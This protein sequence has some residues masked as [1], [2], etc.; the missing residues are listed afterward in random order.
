M[1]KALNGARNLITNGTSKSAISLPLLEK[2]CAALSQLSL[3]HYNILLFKSMFLLAFYSF[4]RVGEFT[5]SQGCSKNTIKIDQVKF[6]TKG[7]N[8]IG[9]FV[10]F[11]NFKH[12]KGKSFSLYIRAI[13]SN[14]CPVLTLKQ[15]INVRPVTN[16]PLFLF[17]DVKPVS[18]S[19]FNTILKSCIMLA[20]G[21]NDNFSAHSLRIGAASH[22][23]S[24]GYTKD[25]IMKMGRWHS[26]AVVKYFK[27]QSFTV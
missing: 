1:R 2:I 26:E 9:L 24:K 23:L 15:Y 11:K 20:Q 4:L 6:K 13:N 22:C 12:S 5:E 19:Y 27:V 7:K 10:L 25:Q 8:V 14:F 21:S 18:A 17:Q 16:G 3:N